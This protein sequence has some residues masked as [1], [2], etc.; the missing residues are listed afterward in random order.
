MGF[1]NMQNGG[2]TAAASAPS[3]VS[4]PD[5]EPEDEDS[6]P[7]YAP[8]TD[9]RRVDNVDDGSQGDDGCQG[10]DEAEDSDEESPAAVVQDLDA[11]L[12]ANRLPVGADVWQHPPPCELK[13][14]HK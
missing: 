6:G 5:S 13:P 11:I 9:P 1:D 2:A 8:D 12:A 7:M 4:A 10:A 3:S 14:L